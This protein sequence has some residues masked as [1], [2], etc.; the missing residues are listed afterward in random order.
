MRLSIHE[1]GLA[2][3]KRGGSLKGAH[4]MAFIPVRTQE[5]WGFL[6]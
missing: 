6:V 2:R 3:N 4:R 5:I 1:T